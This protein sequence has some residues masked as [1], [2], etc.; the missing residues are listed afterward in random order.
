MEHNSKNAQILLIPHTRGWNKLVYERSRWKGQTIKLLQIFNCLIFQLG[1]TL[2]SRFI[3]IVGKGGFF[4][5]LIWW[6]IFFHQNGKWIIFSSHNDLFWNLL[7]FA[8]IFL[9]RMLGIY[10]FIDSWIYKTLY[11]L[12]WDLVLRYLIYLYYNNWNFSLQFLV[13]DSKMGLAWLVECL[14]NLWNFY[15]LNEDYKIGFILVLILQF[16]DKES[17]IGLSTLGKCLPNL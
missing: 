12:S 8:F 7:N 17:K 5:M 11:G 13:K 4:Y 16:L 1:K 6:K 14:L 3:C 10:V 15:S 9:L 2:M